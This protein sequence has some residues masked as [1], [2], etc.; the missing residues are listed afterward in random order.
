MGP[1]ATE[2]NEKDGQQAELFLVFWVLLKE[3]PMMP[4]CRR[5]RR[6]LVGDLFI[7]MDTQR[8]RLQKEWS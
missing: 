5:E 4:W 1:A 8:D 6:S 7:I 2:D 3:N